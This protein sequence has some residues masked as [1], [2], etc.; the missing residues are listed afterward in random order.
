MFPVIIISPYLVLRLLCP[1]GDNDRL[2][3]VSIDIVDIQNN[4]YILFFRLDG[5]EI[6]RLN[7]CNPMPLDSSLLPPH[8]QTFLLKPSRLV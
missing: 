1:A 6:C 7:A 5:A 2:Y 4:G 3:Q 8:A